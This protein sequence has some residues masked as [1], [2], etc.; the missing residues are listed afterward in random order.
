MV[1]SIVTYFS[2]TRKWM[3]INWDWKKVLKLEGVGT[4]NAVN[5]YISVEGAQLGTCRKG[6]DESACIDLTPIQHSSGG[7]VKRGTIGKQCKNNILRSQLIG[8]TM[9]VVRQVV[10]RE[11]KTKKSNVASSLGRTTRQ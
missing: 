7:K 5:L 1:K 10:K 11:A 9:S 4:T 6:K 3:R 8:S 2:I